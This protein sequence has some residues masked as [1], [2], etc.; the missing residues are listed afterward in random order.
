[1]SERIVSGGSVRF[2][3]EDIRHI[4]RHREWRVEKT[5]DGGTL[6]A[7]RGGRE[8]VGQI[9]GKSVLCELMNMLLINWK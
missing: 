4:V 1:L 6:S 2:K 8:E 7:E 3:A 5:N 9:A